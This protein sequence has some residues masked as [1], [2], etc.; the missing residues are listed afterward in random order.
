MTELLAKLPFVGDF[1]LQ[2]WLITGGISI[3][4]A[5]FT[6]YAPKDMIAELVA[7]V[8]AVMQKLVQN[9]NHAVT[10]PVY[11][12]GVAFSKF[13][14]SKLGKDAAQKI[15]NGF[16]VT[17]CAWA[18]AILKAVVDNLIEVLRILEKVPSRF[19]EGMLSDNDKRPKPD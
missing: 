16:F 15:E 2:Q 9:V 8:S 1:G 3:A 5:A 4:L 12:A 6:K 7:K 19:K 13:L 11:L 14:L 10:L 17:L 18:E